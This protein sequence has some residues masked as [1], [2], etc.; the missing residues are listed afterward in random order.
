MLHATQHVTE[1][2]NLWYDIG[3]KYEEQFVGEVCPRLGLDIKINE[4]KE[5]H[6][7][8]CD[9]VVGGSRFADLKRQTKPFFKAHTKYGMSPQYTVTFNR[10]DLINYH[11]KFSPDEFELYFWVSWESEEAYGSC[12]KKMHGVWQCSLRHIVNMAKRPNAIWHNYKRRGAGDPNNNATT[13]LLLD[14]REMD[15]LYYNG[16]GRGYDLLK[17]I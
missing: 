4:Q 2:K 11:G 3:V 13:S 7:W 17:N 6:P 8:A 16:Y 14:L 12:V 15:M 5:K 1:Q 9:L 10:K